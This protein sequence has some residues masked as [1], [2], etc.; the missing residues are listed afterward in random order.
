MTTNGEITHGCGMREL[1]INDPLSK[2][3]VI[4]R[5]DFKKRDKQNQKWMCRGSFGAF[6]ITFFA[7]AIFLMAGHPFWAV[8]MFVIC[9]ISSALL[10]S[11]KLVE[12][13]DVSFFISHDELTDLQL[14]IKTNQD[15]PAASFLVKVQQQERDLTRYEY[16]LLLKRQEDKIIC[17][18]RN[19]ISRLAEEQENQIA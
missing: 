16:E 4:E 11:L 3:A 13:D 15:Q 6:I 18:A 7:T 8:G 17:E 19:Y 12:P 10:I 2:E 5:L 1:T 9:F 14:K